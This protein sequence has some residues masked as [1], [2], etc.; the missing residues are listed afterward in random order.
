MPNIATVLKD[1]ITRLARKE[2]RQQVDP[3]RA[4]VLAQRKAISALKNEVEK[5][6]RDVVKLSKG[7]S[8]NTPAKAG[9]S[10]SGKQSRYSG[11]LLRKLR[12]RLGLS[13]DAFAPLLGAS[14]QTLYNWE[15]TETRPRQEFLDKIALIR[16][17]SKAQVQD[18]LAQ[19]QA[20]VPAAKAKKKAPAKK[21]STA[22]PAAKE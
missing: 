2:M 9:S 16:G 8:K 14:S 6:Q 17:L 18:L 4:Q 13:R 15:Q 20:T 12:E 7:T 1:E 11:A 19:A 5:L 10:E 22:K 3:L 21:G